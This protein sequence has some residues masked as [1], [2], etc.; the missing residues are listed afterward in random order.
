MTADDVL[1]QVSDALV[2]ELGV[3]AER[4]V[5]AATLT[6]DL[7]MDSLDR[8]EF[9]AVLEGRIGTAIEADAIEQIRTVQNVVDLVVGV[10]GEQ[11]W[12]TA[13]S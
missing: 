4:I 11:S 6:E 1:A 9:L 3:S 5:P 2:A 12:P 10:V 7:E 13:T 8:V